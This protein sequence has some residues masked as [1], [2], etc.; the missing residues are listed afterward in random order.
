MEIIR[1]EEKVQLTNPT[2]GERYRSDLVTPE[3]RAKKLGG[4]LCIIPA[5]GEMPYHYH[6]KRESLLFLI[7]GE[8]VEIVEGEEH[9]VKAGDVLYIPAGE[10]HSIINRSDGDLRYLEFFTPVD[11]DFIVVE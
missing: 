9:P 6:E 10:K 2:P 1:T 7:K 3:Q 8:A 4:F 11:E 5:G